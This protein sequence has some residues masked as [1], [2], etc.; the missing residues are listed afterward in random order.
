[1]DYLTVLRL[2]LVGSCRLTRV[3][4]LVA[5]LIRVSALFSHFWVAC[6]WYRVQH[7]WN[8]EVEAESTT[9][10]C[11][12]QNDAKDSERDVLPGPFKIQGTI[13]GQPQT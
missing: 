11:Y 4:V 13:H 8:A 9:T 6:P 1:M 5:S 2:H 10:N 12:R 7:L 3:H